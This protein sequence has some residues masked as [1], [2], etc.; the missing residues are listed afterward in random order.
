MPSRTSALA[1]MVAA[2]TMALTAMELFGE[3]ANLDY[4]G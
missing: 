4:R 2:K 1:V 3:P